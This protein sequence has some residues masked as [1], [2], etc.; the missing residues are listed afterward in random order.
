[1]TEDGRNTRWDAHRISRRQELVSHALRAIRVNGAGVGMDEIA[2][3][4]GTSKTVFYR[5]FGDRAGLYEAVVESV[6][7]YIEQG[8]TTAIAEHEPENLDHLASTLADAY[9]LLVE[10][11]PHIYRF[12]MNGPTP[13]TSSADPLGSM[14][15]RIGDFVGGVILA[16]PGAAGV[17]VECAATWGH[18]LVGFIR[19]VADRWM[20]S[21]QR[22]PRDLVV[23][24]I[25][26]LFA[27]AFAGA[28]ATP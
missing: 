1:M 21:A 16:S 20:D 8:L 7:D 13:G 9:L 15:M 24:H 6:H 28:M 14:P 10:R 19:A 17:S 23:D 26:R 11:D 5:H 12:V 3:R 25:S 18:G 22:E 2:A 27:P 4:A